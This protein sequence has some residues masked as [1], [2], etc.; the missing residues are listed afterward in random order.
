MSSHPCPALN[1]DRGHCSRQPFV[2]NQFLG[3]SIRLRIDCHLSGC[4]VMWINILLALLNGLLTLAL[5]QELVVKSLIFISYALACFHTRPTW[6]LLT[7]QRLQNLP[8]AL[9]YCC[10]WRFYS[11]ELPHSASGWGHPSHIWLIVEHFGL[12]NRCKG[13]GLS[14]GE[15]SLFSSVYPLDRCAMIKIGGK[16]CQ[17]AVPCLIIKGAP[18]PETVGS[19]LKALHID[20]AFSALP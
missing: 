20:S 15:I 11:A 17:M 2:L 13:W 5:W 19:I 7:T 16:I 18:V 12:K 9:K 4:C 10:T 1:R 14:S 3:S 8:F 6:T